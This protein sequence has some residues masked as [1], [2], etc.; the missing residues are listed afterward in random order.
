M[1][2]I[3]PLL[4]IFGFAIFGPNPAET[5]RCPALVLANIHTHS[6]FCTPHT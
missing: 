5:D 1:G 6:K 2:G 4:V 3:L